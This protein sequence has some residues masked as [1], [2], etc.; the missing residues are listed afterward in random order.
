MEL[1]LPPHVS[2]QQ[3]ERA[4]TAF[5]GVVGPEWVLA[6]DQ[7]RETYL[8]AY[9]LGDGHDHAASAAIAPA[10]VEEVQALLRLANEHG[11]PLWPVGRGKNLGYGH[12]APYVPGTV[13]LD[14][15]RMNRIIDVDEKFGHALIEPGVGYFDLYNHLTDNN[16]PLWMSVPG[17]AWGSMI[18]N[19]L[20]RGIGYT[21]FGDHT[22]MLCGLEVVLPQGDLVRTGMGAMAGNKA[23]QHYQHGFGPDWAQMFA[24]SN[25]GVVTKAGVWLQP[26]P[27]MSAKVKIHLPQFDDI[28]WAIDI[29]AELRRRDVIQHNFVFGNYLHDAS[30]FSQRSDWY[31]GP[32]AIPDAVSQKIIEHYDIGW[33]TFSL[34]LF[35]YEGTVQSHMQVLRDMLEPRLGKPL[36]FTEWRKGDPIQNSARGQPS[37]LPLQ[38]VNWHGGRGGH[39]GFSPV[40][41]PDGALA[42]AQ[43]KRMKARFEEFGL[44]YYTSFTMGRRHIS[45]VNLLIYDRDNADMVARSKALFRTLIGDAAQ[46]GYAEYRTHPEFMPDIAATFD[47][48]DNALWRLNERLKDT[49]DPKGILAPGKNGIT[50]SW[51][52]KDPA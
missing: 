14:M 10:S 16:I 25:F 51:Q 41:P 35:G 44:D 19:A 18:G 33:W 8:D 7:D 13:V 50:A 24:Q 11:I 31:D 12:A 5:R 32:G 52:R 22:D 27:E 29:L 49:L 43:A 40:M 42:L 3:F 36:E 20:E 48:N 17:N 38:I 28:A 9:A 47:F 30:V 45:N 21:P 46:S 37:V 15:G 34:S 23:W 2:P 4:L 1:V 39:V 26:E 6:T